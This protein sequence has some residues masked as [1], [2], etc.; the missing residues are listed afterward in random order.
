M[1]YSM[2]EEVQELPSMH[3]ESAKQ[4]TAHTAG[5]F[6]L[7]FPRLHNPCN[8]LFKFLQILSLHLHYGLTEE[9]SVDL[10]QRSE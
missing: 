3:R 10:C 4:R 5:S 1:K 7:N 2:V 6:F 8:V 9:P